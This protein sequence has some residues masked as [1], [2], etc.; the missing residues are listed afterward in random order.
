[1]DNVW[2]LH[3]TVD[4]LSLVKS[5]LSIICLGHL[6]LVGLIIGLGENWLVEQSRSGGLGARVLLDFLG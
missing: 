6:G 4:F 1:M 3:E 2:R 5:Q